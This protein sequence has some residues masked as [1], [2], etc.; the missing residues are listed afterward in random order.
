VAIRADTLVKDA[1]FMTRAGVI[2][3]VTVFLIA[4][5]VWSHSRR[6]RRRLLVR[7]SAGTRLRNSRAG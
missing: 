1:A 5:V 6:K 4:F 3:S 7:T 2:L